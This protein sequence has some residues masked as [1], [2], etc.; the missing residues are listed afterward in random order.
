MHSLPLTHLPLTLLTHYFQLI[1]KRTN[2]FWT[3]GRLG[4]WAIARLPDCQIHVQMLNYSFLRMGNSIVIFS[5]LYNVLANEFWTIGR[6]GDWAI[7]RLPDC[8]IARLPGKGYVLSCTKIGL[9]KSAPKS[10]KI[11]NFKFFQKVSRKNLLPPKPIKSA[12]RVV[13]SRVNEVT[14]HQNSKFF[15]KVSR[16]NQLYLSLGVPLFRLCIKW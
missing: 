11:Q 10:R 5:K 12:I 14:V 3:I 15:Q 8:Q 6:L 4:D 1:S 9:F 7:A 13:R 2:E 16:K